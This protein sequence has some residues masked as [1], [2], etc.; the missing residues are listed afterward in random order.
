[1]PHY[2]YELELLVK[3]Y[4]IFN[5]EGTI[6]AR[7]RSVAHC[8][9]W[10]MSSY[11]STARLASPSLSFCRWPMASS[12]SCHSRRLNG[13]FARPA[14][15]SLLRQNGVPNSHSQDVLDMEYARRR[16]FNLL[17][18]EFG[19]Y[20]ISLLTDPYLVSET[21][22]EFCSYSKVQSTRYSYKLT[23]CSN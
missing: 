13:K 23:N 1:M 6:S 8:G 12:A 14:G 16:A 2:I 19:L 9:D 20:L 4:N 11:T 10:S 5:L 18:V 7:T 17:I 15:L 22:S 21:T 3:K